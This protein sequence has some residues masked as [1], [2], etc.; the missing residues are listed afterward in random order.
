VNR[1]RDL[2]ARIDASLIGLAVVAVGTAVEFGAG[3]AL[4]VT[5][6]ATFLASEVAG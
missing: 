3:W 5:G 4:I 2:L 6:A 1:V